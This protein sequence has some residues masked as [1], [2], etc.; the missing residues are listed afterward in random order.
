MPADES[1]LRVALV[2]AGFNAP[3]T[4]GLLQGAE[5]FLAEASVDWTVVRV[6]GSF[7]LPV[8]C[9]AA[10]RQGYDAVV[11]LGAVIKGDTDHYEHIAREAARGLMDVA[12]ETGV[13]VGFGVL[14]TRASEHA[15]ERS[16]PGPGN[17]GIEAAE[18][19]VQAARALR[20]L[21]G[22]E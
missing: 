5:S 19:A 4:E 14:T 13:P 6:P 9:R 10:A 22:Q 18:A 12:L 21:A 8:V 16:R 1:R 3:V 2:V 15:I 20:E 7:E 17:K 11:A